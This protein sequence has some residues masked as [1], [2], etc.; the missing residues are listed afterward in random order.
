[1]YK[2]VLAFIDAVKQKDNCPLSIEEY[3]QLAEQAV[4]DK[5]VGIHYTSMQDM[6]KSERIWRRT[7]LLSS[8]EE[9]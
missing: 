7:S 5:R 3:R 8:H 1:M 9:L 2:A 4:K 6:R